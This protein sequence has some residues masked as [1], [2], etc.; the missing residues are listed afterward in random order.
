MNESMGKPNKRPAR[1]KGSLFL[2]G[3]MGAGKTTIGLQL[4]K[5][6]KREFYDS[7]KVIEA[8]TGATIPLI[9]ELEGE[10]GFRK[11]EIA[12]IN[13]LTQLPNIVLATGGGAVLREENRQALTSRGTVIYLKASL[14]QLVKRTSKDRNRPLLQTEN[15]RARLAQILAEREPL[16]ESTAHIVV[17]TGNQTVRGIVHTILERMK[18][19]E[20]APQTD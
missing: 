13:D 14:D 3:P 7:D 10:E 19:R 1:P 15:P 6:L 5:S 8:R 11:R 12:A 4:A 17:E 16:Y 18:T 20:T 9:F 2:I